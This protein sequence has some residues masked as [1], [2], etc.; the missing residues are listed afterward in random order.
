MK[1]PTMSIVASLACTVPTLAQTTGPSTTV[2]PYLVSSLSNVTIES[3]LT[4]DDQSASN[5]YSM[6]GIPD[7]MGA[8]DNGNGTF[9][10]LLNHELNT[11]QGI[12]RAHGS[13]GAFVSKLIINKRTHEVV[14]G[15]DQ[16]QALFDWNPSTNSYDTV[17]TT[18]FDRM[19]S[20]DLPPL[21]A[22]YNSATGL[23]SQER[24][25]FNGE[26]TGGGRAYGH[27][28][29]GPDA[30][31]SY[32][33]EHLGFAAFENVLLSPTEQDLTI[34]AMTDDASNGEVYFYVGS[35]NNTGVTEVEK[36]GLIGGKLYAL[37]VPGKP[38]EISRNQDT[39]IGM[40]ETFTL[41]LIGEPGNY[42]I[43][44]DDM[45]ARGMDTF[46]PLDASQTFESL[47]MG[48]PEDGVWDTR[49]GFENTFYFVSKGTSTDGNNTPTRL[50]KLEFNNI[51]N[52]TAGGT[53]TMLLDGPMA[54]MGSMDNMT[55]EVI[56]GAPKVY[57]QEDLGS[58][59][60]LSRI[61]EYDV[62]TGRLETIATH[63]GDFFYTGGASF[64]TTNEESSGIISLKETLG[65][66]WFVASIQSHTSTGLSDSDEQVEHGQICLLNIA[67][68]G[69]D[70]LRETAIA[71][72]S[73]W[74][75]SVNEG[76]PG[77]T[78]FETAF[79]D[80]AWSTGTAPIGYGD[81]IETTTDLEQPGTPRPAANY[82]RKEF[83]L[84]NPE[85]VAF[86]EL[87]LK[88]DD[89]AVVYLNGI[90]V[91][92]SNTPADLS[93]NHDSY[94]GQDANP[95]YAWHIVS[96]TC[97]DVALQATNV[98][99]V[100]VL[101]GDNGSSDMR[102]DA[103]LI[104]FN[105][106][107][108]GPASAPATPA[109]LVATGSATDQIDVTWD[110]Q[111]D[112]DFFQLEHKAATDLVWSVV[113]SNIPGNFTSYSDSD[114]DE[115]VDYSYR[116]VGFNLSGKSEVS[117]VAT[118]STLTNPIPQ[119]FSEGFDAGYGLFTVTSLGNDNAG[120]S[121]DD[122]RLQGNGYGAG[123][124]PSD[125][126]LI[127][128]DPVPMD[129]YTEETFEFTFEYDF[130]GPSLD[131]LYSSDY[132][133]GNDPTNFTWTTLA[134]YDTNN[135]TGEPTNVV[136]DVSGIED[137]A[138]DVYF[139]F[140]YGSVG[141]GGGESARVYLYDVTM[142]G[143]FSPPKLTPLVDFEADFAGWTSFNLS[144][145]YSWFL[146]SED[147]QF[148]AFNNNYGSGAGGETN[149]TA[150]DDWLVSPTVT[151]V[152][153]DN[154]TISFDYFEQYGDNIDQ[155]VS[156]LV[157]NTY[158]GG[159]PDIADFVDITP[160]TL[161]SAAGS[162]GAAEWMETGPISIPLTGEVTIAF[163]YQSAGNGGGTTR[164]FGIDQVCI[165]KGLEAPELAVDFISAFA[166]ST[167]SSL[168]T[169]QITT[170]TPLNFTAATQNAN[171]EVTYEWDFD[172]DGTVD[173]ASG[174]QVTYTFPTAGL[175]TVKLTATDEVSTA[176]QTAMIDVAFATIEVLEENSASLRVATFNTSLNRNSLGELAS[177]LST[178]NNAQ[179]QAIAEIIQLIDADVILINEFDYDSSN[180]S[181]DLFRTN[182]LEVGQ[183]GAEP[184]FYPY[185]Y[186]APSNT[187]ILSGFDLDNDGTVNGDGDDAFGFGNFEGQYGFIVLSKY[188]IDSDAARTFQTFLWKDMPG[189]LLPVRLPAGD[190]YDSDEVDILR[191]SSKSHWDVPVIVNGETI[192][193]LASHPTPPVFDDG[194]DRDLD[195]YDDAD[196]TTAIFDWNGR[197]NSDEIR[198]WA[199][200]IDPAESSYIYDDNGE[201]GG[202]EEGA[203]FVILGDQN[204]D[205]VDGDSS[206]PAIASLLQ[207]PLVDTSF[208]PSS[209]GALEFVEATR[210]TYSNPGEKTS[211]FQLRADYVLSSVAKLDIADGGHFWPVST[212]IRYGTANNTD[213]RLVYLDLEVDYTDLTLAQFAAAYGADPSDEETLLAYAF[214]IAPGTNTEL[215]ID[216]GGNVITRGK[217]AFS[218][219]T[220]VNEVGLALTF[221]RRKNAEEAELVYILEYSSDLITWF[222]SDEE[223]VVMGEDGE[224]EVV[225]GMLP[226]FTPD[227]A[228]SR[229]FRVRINTP[230][231]SSTAARQVLTPERSIALGADINGVSVRNHGLVG[232][233]RLS[234]DTLDVFGETMGAASGL[235]ITDWAYNAVSGEYS[236]VFQVLPDRG[237]NANGIFSNYGARVHEVDFTFTPYY[238]AGPVGQTQIVPTYNDVSTKLT[239]QDGGVTKFTTGLDNTGVGTLFG[240]SVGTAMA[241]NGP[242]GATEELMALDAEAIHLFSDGSGYISDEYGTYIVRFNASMEMTGIT[243]LPEASRP[244]QGGALNFTSVGAPDT[245]RRNN[246]GLEGMSVSP[247]ET[248]LIAVMQSA[249][250]QDN[251]AG[252]AGRK[253][254]RIY[255]FDIVGANRENPVLIEEYALELPTLDTDGDGSGIDRTAA[256][257]EIVAIDNFRFLMLPRDSSGLGTGSDNPSVVK[258]IDLVDYS[259]ATNL[260]GTYD[261]EGAAIAPGG[262][263]EPGI[264]PAESAQ[265]INMVATADLE[266]F[267]F[268]T[269]NA[270]PDQF[271]FNEKWEG[272]GLVPNPATPE[273]N[274]YFLF[275]ANDNDF[276]S[277][278]VMRLDENGDLVSE[279]DQT[280]GGI[281]NDAVFLAY[282]ITID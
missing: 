84:D 26:E 83:T 277:S 163:R 227:L 102:F 155:P 218:I 231:T 104:A 137:S 91:A 199:D 156:V 220:D 224:M 150:A 153:E 130:S 100:V 62:N 171:G 256:S 27:V 253:M 268:N 190:R 276:Q 245:G 269:D 108:D 125:D 14:S 270:N 238:G 146:D 48:G 45:E 168:P 98:L 261:G 78:W 243:Q 188:P 267:G 19:C 123:D 152:A 159:T 177:D 106:S 32:H 244:Y 99:A 122:S 65:E 209:A 273:T 206:G 55:F 5:G 24:I 30:G 57:I 29:T 215:A 88:R 47:K 272:F 79:D 23:G 170:A 81:A 223:L 110:A 194:T 189:N 86:F 13:A 241:A 135:V 36:A 212:D 92:R 181:L 187:G 85:D 141:G 282:A 70:Y 257:S 117:A 56:D 37:A 167:L 9:T 248:R 33:L 169:A 162:N 198:F 204:A 182:Y 11:T 134:S 216:E 18:L 34:A 154:A 143:T 274:D 6:V 195:G 208:T 279:G 38:Y 157:S 131:V 43:D 139:A 205:P 12:A 69:E 127:K 193:I 22:T 54:R 90:E 50:W 183:N 213:H 124:E 64:Q 165:A 61:Y 101:Q 1:K 136:L 113:A 58:D 20:A 109:N 121:V 164:F 219:E 179:A 60:R 15:E 80:S 77:A 233:G 96:L 236:G 186:N 126:W 202:L 192:H 52:P 207:H 278:N 2:D 254:T 72:Q 46:M 93:I 63:N 174:P 172:N 105:K 176:T 138:G 210:P 149:G 95:E 68:R 82:F 3:I 173:D 271:T 25:F 44:G 151:I 250:I 262:V 112:V 237:F 259:N 229:F 239:Y 232:A 94:S 265:V 132:E 228:K 133:P 114:L 180:T 35:K 275:V 21:T 280:A 166:E 203:A 234:G 255:V 200:Y 258:S 230:A 116:L 17:G 10:L 145:A 115:G 148:G 129:F 51:T 226:A 71:Q 31:K 247:D 263:L 66:G 197:R 158:P 178:P 196:G 142:R 260:I 53:M 111:S 118:T 67:N 42:P 225:R 89:S 41:K 249:L 264:I 161:N 252:N 251:G 16:I 160:A 74:S 49:A 185:A 211:T 87:Y 242:G 222:E 107:P 281:V 73:E 39:E 266:K 75:Y 140:R 221:L 246:Q 28:L 240:Q 119:I 120:W 7:G 147:D 184:V 175:H 128:T 217:E 144:S 40:T 235:F 76:D 8:Y 201:F 97:E 214:G 191:L 103:E 59:A 4:V